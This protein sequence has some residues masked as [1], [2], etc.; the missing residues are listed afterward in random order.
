MILKCNKK[1]PIRIIQL[2]QLT[3]QES[4]IIK[5]VIIKLEPEHCEDLKA[6]I[7]KINLQFKALIL[8]GI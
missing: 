4:L 3:P 2:Q 8:Q 1:N 7:L 6:D 5:P